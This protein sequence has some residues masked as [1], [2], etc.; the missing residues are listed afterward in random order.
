MNKKRKQRGKEMKGL[1]FPVAENLSAMPESYQSF[2][3]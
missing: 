1:V 3:T 2:I